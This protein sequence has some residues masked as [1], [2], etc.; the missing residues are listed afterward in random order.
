MYNPTSKSTVVHVRSVYY[1]TLYF[2][3]LIQVY[4]NYAN[5]VR[6]RSLFAGV[7]DSAKKPREGFRVR[8]LSS[9]FS[10]FRVQRARLLLIVARLI[11]QRRSHEDQVRLGRVRMIEALRHSHRA[12]AEDAS[13]CLH[14]ARP[15]VRGVHDEEF[16][17]RL[18]D[19]PREDAKIVYRRRALETAEHLLLRR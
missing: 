13:H 2:T 10:R 15:T 7:G 12:V 6:I 19:L 18:H 14:H 8:A 4:N 16:A 11:A 5:N 3:V 1:A 17:V 9:P